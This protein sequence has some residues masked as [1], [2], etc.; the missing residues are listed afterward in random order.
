MNDCDLES[1]M[2]RAW[3]KTQQELYDLLE[4][5]HQPQPWELLTLIKEY[6]TRRFINIGQ[7]FAWWASYEDY[8]HAF[9]LNKE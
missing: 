2:H 1:W 5:D 6:Q 3:I 7:Y 8:K 4:I 9:V